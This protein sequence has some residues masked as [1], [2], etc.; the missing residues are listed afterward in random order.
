MVGTQQVLGII[1]HEG[2]NQGK[3]NWITAISNF[4]WSSFIST[5][6]L[7]YKFIPKPTLK[8]REEIQYKHNQNHKHGPR[9]NLS[10]SSIIMWGSK[11]LLTM[12][13][14]DISV[15]TLQR[16]YTLPTIR[17]FLDARVCKALKHFQREWQGFT[18]RPLQRFPNLQR[19]AKV[20]G[21]SGHN[22]P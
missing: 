13:T 2:Q 15:F 14:A 8:E 1:W 9:F 12:N 3:A 19:S 17:V 10:S 21:R 7:R 6:L 18:T 22:P 5:W 11:P 20:S 16:L 4:S